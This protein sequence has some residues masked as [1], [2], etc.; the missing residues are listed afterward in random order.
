MLD[1]TSATHPTYPGF[2]VCVVLS[3]PPFPNSRKEIDYPVGLP[4]VV[5]D[6]EPKHLHWG[7]VSL[8][9]G[10]MLTAG[11][12]GWTAVVTGTGA[13][14]EVARAAAYARA[15]RVQAPNLRYRLDIGERVM[16]GQLGQLSNLGWLAD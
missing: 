1:R 4:V 8:V 15:A 5:A 7:E 9:E 13:S 2:A 11:L 12:Y 6:I 16:G 10:Q 3:T 14:I